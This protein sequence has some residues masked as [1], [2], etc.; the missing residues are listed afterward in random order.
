MIGELLASVP[1][2]EKHLT[3]AISEDEAVQF[4]IDTLDLAEALEALI[5][6]SGNSMRLP[7]TKVRLKDG[8]KIMALLD[9]SL[10]INIMTRELIESANLAIR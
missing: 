6:Y 3:K 9:T 8:S 7:K 5:S 1:A 4:C 10:E 2:I